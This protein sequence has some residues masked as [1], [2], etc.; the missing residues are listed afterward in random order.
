LDTTRDLLA[1]TAPG[2]FVVSESGMRDAADV[3]TVVGHGARGVL[4][5][6]SLMRAGDPAAVVAA[7]KAVR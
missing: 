1:R 7:I 4:V 5:G 6:E 2:T 3:A